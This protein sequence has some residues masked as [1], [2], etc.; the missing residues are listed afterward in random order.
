MK[1]ISD[2]VLKYDHNNDV[3]II[4]NSQSDANTD[5]TEV[6]SQ[7]LKLTMIPD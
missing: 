2:I 5:V 1:T 3:S 6:L 7:Y 4:N